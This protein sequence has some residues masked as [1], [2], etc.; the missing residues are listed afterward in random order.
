MNSSKTIPNSTPG[1]PPPPPLENPDQGN[2]PREL[3]TKN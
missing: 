2:P 3:P 1:N